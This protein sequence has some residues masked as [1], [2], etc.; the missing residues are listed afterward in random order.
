MHHGPMIRDYNQNKIY[1]R[2]CVVHYIARKTQGNMQ[3]E[4]Y[5]GA[6]RMRP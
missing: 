1:V 2:V 3:G 4:G 5:G 6:G